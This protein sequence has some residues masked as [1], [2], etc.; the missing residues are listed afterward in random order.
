MFLAQL[1]GSKRNFNI[2]NVL[3]NKF[4]KCDDMF[5]NFSLL[6]LTDFHHDTEFMLF[7]CF[8][9]FQL[10]CVNML[11][12]PFFFVTLLY[13]LCFPGDLIKLIKGSHPKNRKLVCH[14]KL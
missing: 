13:M 9:T 4:Q 11:M 10:S 12:Q 8:W 1:K 2:N 14:M 7:L 5:K 3:S 6:D